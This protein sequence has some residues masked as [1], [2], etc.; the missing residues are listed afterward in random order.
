M[1]LYQPR[2]I[3]KRMAKLL[4]PQTVLKDRYL[5]AGPIGQGGMG[6]VYRA[7]DTLLAG[8]ICAVKEIAPDADVAL[9]ALTQL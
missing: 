5:I 8:R 9:E 4:E 1:T 7:E 6:A 2:A 3:I